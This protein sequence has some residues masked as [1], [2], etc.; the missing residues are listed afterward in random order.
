VK[1]LV[2][3]THPIQYQAPWFRA[4]AVAPSLELVVAF[5]YLPPAREQGVGFGVPFEWDVPLL[6]GYRWL[7]MSRR[8][9]RPRLDRFWSL[10]VGGL[11]ALLRRERPDI[12][13][14]TGWNSIALLQALAMA[15]RHGIPA[16][17]RGES[18]D[19]RP[20]RRAV[21]WL[22]LA[23][24]GR[25]SAA[26]AI[27]AANRDFL[28]ARGVPAERIFDAPYFVDNQRFAAAA[29]AERAHRDAH[30]AKWD[31][32]P[33]RFCL[34]FAGK[35]IGKK[36][37]GDLLDAFARSPALRERAELLLVGDGELRAELA[38]RVEAE[39]LPVR[40]AGFLNQG[41][42]ARAYAAA[43][44]LV[45]PSDAGETWGLVVNEAMACGLPAIVSDLV[46]CGPDLVTPGETGWIHACGDAAA[47]AAA[48]EEAAADPERS[49]RMG[50]AARDRI[51]ARYTVERSVDAVV[52]AV[53]AVTAERRR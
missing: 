51:F 34:L 13:L 41:E 42:I 5:A 15:R 9:R 48:M 20:R 43:D 24:L 29:A 12:V 10:R 26:L 3:A 50:E 37:P 47:L 14:V 18:N 31:L 23:L 25:Y 38:R 2:F 36:R 22:Q 53:R 35:L 40:F 39:H 16:L 44:A 46:G 8:S 52:E 4:L 27:G 17:V 11:G 49:R 32:T 30:R 28:V 19:L 6:D 33:D 7:E 1:L 45:L 21:R